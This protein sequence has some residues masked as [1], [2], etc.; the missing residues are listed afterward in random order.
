[1]D[2]SKYK[3][4]GLGG[5]ITEY[6]QN[7]S[8]VLRQNQLNLNKAQAKALTNVP[9]QGLGALGD[10]VMNYGLSNFDLSE[11]KLNNQMAY[12]GKVG[13]NVSVEVEDEEVAEM[14]NK[15]M[16]K[17]KGK[18]HEQGGIDV[19][20]PVGTTVYSDRIKV[21][22]KTLAERKKEREKKKRDLSKLLDLR[23]SDSIL[24]NTEKRMNFLN[25][26]EE[27]LDTSLQELVNNID[28]S[29]KMS[30]GG[31]VKPYPGIF[32]TNAYRKNPSTNPGAESSEE[33]EGFENVENFQG[34]NNNS[35][36]NYLNLPNIPNMPDM[37]MGDY[38]SMFGTIQAAIS[39]MKNTLKNQANT[40]PNVNVYSDYGEDSLNT[41]KETENVISQ[42]RDYNI[43]NNNLN[44]TVEQR[45]NRN[46]AR[47]INTLRGLD[48]AT[49]YQK[50]IL[51]EKAIVTYL[52]QINEY[53]NQFANMEL[54]VEGVRKR[55]EE[56]KNLANQQ[57]Q[58]N[59][60]TQLGQD[61]VSKAL[62]VQQLGKQFNDIFGRETTMNLLNQLSQYGIELDI[63]GK[64]KK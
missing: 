28:K 9:L 1:M 49:N 12:G 57:D 41:L 23:K 35:L 10:I 40:Q 22:G 42:N 7:P 25:E 29:D 24:T 50:D 26:E 34:L 21:D 48:I 13:N 56:A 54:Q 52:N 31:T 27:S 62:G 60:Y 17:F 63:K 33:F 5:R 43:K 4:L 20:L 38:I 18:K 44:R 19:N 14:P 30:Y 58:D 32:N 47:G 59:F 6:M 64:P 3:K 11:L 2:K 39:P 45:N 46:S 16:V 37:T 61:K 51:D 15:Q 55:G 53:K 8:D 36:S